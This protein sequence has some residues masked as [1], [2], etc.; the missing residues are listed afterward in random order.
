MEVNYEELKERYGLQGEC[1][2]I[3]ENIPDVMDRNKIA[4]GTDKWILPYVGIHSLFL[5]AVGFMGRAG[6]CL[7][8][9]G[10]QPA[11]LGGYGRLIHSNLAILICI[12]I[13]GMLKDWLFRIYVTYAPGNFYMLATMEPVQGK[14]AVEKWGDWM[15]G[16]IQRMAR[17]TNPLVM[18]LVPLLID[19]MALMRA[20]ESLAVL[21]NLFIS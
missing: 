17:L 6:W 20:H 8:Q 19:F 5:V 2:V 11:G 10:R 3:P 7:Y 1:P 13:Q 15:Q 12:G 14:E 4:F 21:G 9:I 16:E 18:I